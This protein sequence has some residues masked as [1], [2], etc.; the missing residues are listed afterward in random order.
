MGPGGKGEVG[1]GRVGQVR[2][3]GVG[4]TLLVDWVL[5]H[6]LKSVRIVSVRGVTQLVDCHLIVGLT[7]SPLSC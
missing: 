5:S 2:V 4:V 3:E 6:I 7:V 1:M